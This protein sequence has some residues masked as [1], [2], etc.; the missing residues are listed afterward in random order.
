MSSRV[1]EKHPGVCGGHATVV[2]TRVLIWLLEQARR[3]GATDADLLRAYEILGAEDLA[4][5]WDYA[6]CHSDE[7]DQAIRDNEAA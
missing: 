7:I 1:I 6:R 2:R 4:E 3:S 5:V